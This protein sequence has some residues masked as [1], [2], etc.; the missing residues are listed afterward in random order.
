MAWF[1][2]CSPINCGTEI[3]RAHAFR[4]ETDS[5]SHRYHLLT[6]ICVCWKKILLLRKPI[7]PGIREMEKEREKARESGAEV[8][9]DLRRK[10][11]RMFFCWYKKDSR[12]LPVFPIHASW[13]IWHTRRR[14][15]WC[16]NIA[17]HT[18]YFSRRLSVQSIFFDTV[19][20]CGWLV[21][22]I[23]HSYRRFCSLLQ[24]R[25]FLK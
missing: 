4:R 16:G 18:V 22:S 3:G 10:K 14:W 8:P 25:A 5:S 12:F 24:R 20:W 23:M 2:T 11:N 13:F 6:N 1:R 17:H 15:I 21:G 19:P 7:Y 9:W